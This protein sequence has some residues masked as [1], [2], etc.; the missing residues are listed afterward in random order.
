MKQGRTYFVRRG[1]GVHRSV[2]I[3]KTRVVHVSVLL[4]ESNYLH[5][6]ILPNSEYSDHHAKRNVDTVTTS[7]RIHNPIRLLQRQFTEFEC[8]NPIMSCCFIP[9]R[10]N[11]ILIHEGERTSAASACRELTSTVML[12]RECSQ[13]N[14]CPEESYSRSTVSSEY[15]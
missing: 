9:T 3:F 12:T 15:T 13:Y 5:F 10:T 1:A 6:S 4:R 7:I 8:G 14:K 2:H 11:I